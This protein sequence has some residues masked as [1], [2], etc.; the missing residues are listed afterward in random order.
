MDD[1]IRASALLTNDDNEDEVAG[2]LG[3]EGEET[4]KSGEDDGGDDVDMGGWEEN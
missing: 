3:E 4:F 2:D 1:L